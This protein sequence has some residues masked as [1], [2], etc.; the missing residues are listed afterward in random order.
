MAFE[1]FKACSGSTATCAPTKPIIS[2]GFT[3][4]I[5]SAVLTSARNE[6]VL[7]WM[8]H[9]SNS[10]ARGRT[11]SSLMFAAGASMSL[12][13]GTMA[14]GWASQVGYQKERTSRRAWNRDPAPP[15]K[16]SNDGGF[17]NK[18]FF[19]ADCL[20]VAGGLAWPPKRVVKRLGS[21]SPRRRGEGHA[22]DSRVVERPP[23][24]RAQERGQLVGE[25]LRVRGHF[26]PPVPAHRGMA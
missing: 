23:D 13:S 10:L 22:T 2:F 8:K 25:A 21:R 14:A 20:S 26:M 7:V 9:S 1:N 16:P 15:S 3:S 4:F 6:G 17:R 5:A 18:L 24:S 19:I 11:S 12:L